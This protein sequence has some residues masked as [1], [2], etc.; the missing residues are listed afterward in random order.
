MFLYEILGHRAIL[1]L[2]Y[3]GSIKNF[4]YINEAFEPWPLPKVVTMSSKTFSEPVIR[5]NLELQLFQRM[6]YIFIC[7]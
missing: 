1:A 3:A 6:L 7:W 2:T 4:S 5:P